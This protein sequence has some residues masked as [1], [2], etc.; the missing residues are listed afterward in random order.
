MQLR[1]ATP[2]TTALPIID[3]SALDGGGAQRGSLAEAISAACRD[4]GFFYISNHAVPGALIDRVVAEAR[5]FF[6]LPLAEKNAV[7]MAKSAC[8]RGYDP[9]RGQILEPGTPPD[10][11]ESFFVGVEVPDGDPRL[12]GGHFGPN[13][14]PATRPAFRAAMETYHSVMRDLSAKMMGGIA[15]SLG[16]EK[17][18]FADFCREPIANLRLLHYPPQEP[19]PAP[20]EKGCGAHTDFGGLTILWQDEVG[21]LQ[22]HKPDRGWIDAPPIPGT[23]VVNLG[24]MIARWTN[25][26][27]RSTLHRVVNRS[28][29]DRYSIPF[30]YTGNPDHLV[31]C[32]PTC[33]VAGEAPHYPAITVAGH[34]AERYR[35]PGFLGATPT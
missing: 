28:G 27:Y 24:D 26:R 4:S 15:L 3:I 29:R 8:R 17:D 30:F 32:I 33:R 31:E 10:L 11:K 13:Q 35:Q 25:N 5:G 16:L 23:F 19:N 9:L 2:Q 34:I 21:G 20:G 6:A 18:Y 22:I 12:A 14:W 7:S 1:A